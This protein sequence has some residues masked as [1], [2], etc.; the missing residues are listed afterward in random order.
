MTKTATQRS[1]ARRAQ[2]TAAAGQAAT[3]MAFDAGFRKAAEVLGVD[4]AALYK[5]AAVS[6]FVWRALPDE[7]RGALLYH[8]LADP[9]TLVPLVSTIGGMHQVGAAL[10]PK[11]EASKTERAIRGAAGLGLTVGGMYAMTDDSTRSSVRN[12]VYKLLG[13]L[14]KPRTV[15]HVAGKMAGGTG[16]A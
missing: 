4:P 8:G 3:K 10:N 12:A 15:A 14:G 5:R 16:R 13:K 1:I 7:S 2:L 9:G 6:D 11:R